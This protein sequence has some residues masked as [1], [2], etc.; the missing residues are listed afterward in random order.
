VHE[1]VH[2]SAVLVH[3]SAQICA[4]YDIF[5]ILCESY[6]QKT[7]YYLVDAQR[8]ARCF[9]WAWYPREGKLCPSHRIFGRFPWTHFPRPSRFLGLLPRTTHVLSENE[10][11]VRGGMECIRTRVRSPIQS[12]TRN[13]NSVI[14]KICRIVLFFGADFTFSPD[15]PRR[16]RTCVMA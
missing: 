4:F 13:S 1:S 11:F 15:I 16:N 5:Y 7:A 3:C 2:C 8:A 6:A 12:M 9:S 14:A 10:W